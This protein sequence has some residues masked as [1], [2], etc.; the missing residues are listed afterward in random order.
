MVCQEEQAAND[1]APTKEETQKLVQ[2]PDRRIKPI[3]YTMVSSGIRI[4]A[5]D[6]LRWKGVKPFED[7]NG[8]VLAAKLTVYAGDSEEYYSFLT[9]EA[10]NAL[11][12]W[13]EFRASYGEK[14]DGN[15]WLMR[16]IWQ[17]TNINYGAR[18]GLAKYPKKLRSSGIKRI[19]E[20]ALWEQGIRKPLKDGEKRHE[21]K[22]AHGFRKYFKS[23]AEQV[24][25]P[26]N[27]EVIM[28][29]DIGVSSSYYKPQEKEIL[30]DYLNAVELLSIND[31]EEKLQAKVS[32][33][34][35]RSKEGIYHMHG[36][37]LEKEKEIELLRHKDAMNSDAISALSD[38]LHYVVSEIENLKRRH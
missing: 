13:M 14:I 6:Y 18:L 19:L 10:Y 37:L 33:I 32:E 29:H 28:G 11:K 24:M 36:R 23:R 38:K 7:E 5:W 15:S 20:R 12:D 26:I 17:T 25:K 2:Y 27:V 8:Q 21:W 22:G 4:G 9:P 1:R 16:D 3:V 35:Q 30:A 31:D 34:E